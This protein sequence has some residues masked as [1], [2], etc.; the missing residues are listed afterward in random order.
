MNRVNRVNQVKP[1]RALWVSTSPATRGGVA[2][3]VRSI[4]TTSLWDDWRIQHISTHRDGSHLARVGAFA[5]GATRFGWVLLTDRPDVV[6]LHTA[7]YGS[8]VRKSL[9]AGLCRRAGV[10]FVLQVHGGAFVE[11]HDR[12]PG[13]AQRWIRSTLTASGC[14]LALGERWARQLRRIAPDARIEVVRNGVRPGPVHAGPTPTGERQAGE[15]QAGERQAGPVHVLF[16]GD[17]TADKGVFVLVEAWA[18]VV[19]Q[20]A[21]RAV[22]LTVAGGG[23]LARLRAAIDVAGVADSVSAPGWIAAEDVPALIASAHV[24]VL[25]S[26]HE[27]QPMS[28]LE[29]MAQGLCVVATDVGGIPD[30]VGD[31]GILVAPDDVTALARALTTVLDD[32]VRRLLGARA[33]ERIRSEFDVTLAARR[34]DEIYRAILRRR[35]ADDAHRK[36]TRREQDGTAGITPQSAAPPPARPS[37]QTRD[38][39]VAG[40]PRPC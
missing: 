13:W 39:P 9:L 33:R 31:A 14:V 18:R 26:R 8:F 11:F 27:G 4:R 19:E 20:S 37:A 29:A 16:L 25:P 5:R 38:G 12:S 2:S 24:L 15:R 36:P 28:V 3:A 30:A 10:P 34:L 23:D 32:D 35:P 22:R 40:P 1:P 21:G 6:H 17:V 7:S